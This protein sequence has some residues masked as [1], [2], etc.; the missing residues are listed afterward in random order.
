M[1][2]PPLDRAGFPVTDHLHF[3]N[4]AGI[5]VLPQAA[6]DQVARCAADLAACGSEAFTGWEAQQDR[7]RAAG[8]RMMGV[9]AASVALLKNTTEGL[10]FVA[11]GL[12]WSPGDR[13][14]VPNHE[15]PSTIHPWLSLRDE[16]VVVDRIDPVGP[17]RTLPLERFE[18][19]LRA[20]PV[21]VVAVSWVQYGRGHRVDLATLASLCHAH[22]ALLCVDAIQ[23][24]GLIPARFDAWGVDFA[25][26]GGH[27]WLLGPMGVGLFYLA[28]RNLHLL[29]P[30]ESGWMSVADRDDYD[31]PELV[32]APDARRFE[33]GSANVLGV[34]A[35]GASLD[36]LEDVGV[37]AVWRHVDV[38]DDRLVEGLGAAGIE[39]L[40]DRS[41]SGRSGIVTFDVGAHEPSAVNAVLRD[42]GFV[43]APRGGGI[44]VSPHGYTT[45]DEVDALVEAAARIVAG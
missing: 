9:E 31:N 37:D 45:V 33:G 15:F 6:V 30:L 3:F 36:L 34:A 35:L 25:S 4:H 24:V 38:L 2:S 11:N 27:K 43:C 8:A 7:A 17:G 40:S 41:P 42:A 44:R 5:T 14:L 18:E 21:R 1:A 32:H 22:G 16:G 26:C 39:V 20:R 28:P 12:R 19:A 23:A 10:S 29:R 13:V